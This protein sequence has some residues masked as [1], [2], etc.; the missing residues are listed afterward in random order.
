MIFDEKVK[1]QASAYFGQHQRS[2]A[3]IEA[4][5]S[6]VLVVILASF[7]FNYGRF[8]TANFGRMPWQGGAPFRPSGDELQLETLGTW[9]DPGRTWGSVVPGNVGLSWGPNIWHRWVEGWSSGIQLKTV[10]S[11]AD[12]SNAGAFGISWLRQSSGRSHI[13]DASRAP[14]TASS[15]S[16]QCQGSWIVLDSHLGVDAFISHHLALFWGPRWRKVANML[17][18]TVASDILK[19]YKVTIVAMVINDQGLW[20]PE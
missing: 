2:L 17:T 9:L 14:C 18:D 12:A 5:G 13:I 20:R 11:E 8:A 10:G 3:H 1:K 4:V 19:W 7:L 6:W 16:A 15:T